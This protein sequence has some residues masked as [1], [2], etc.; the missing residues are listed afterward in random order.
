MTRTTPE[1]EPSSPD[2]RTTPVGGH[3]NFSD[4]KEGEGNECS[5]VRQDKLP[6]EEIVPILNHPAPMTW[7]L[8]AADPATRDF[9]GQYV[10]PGG[11]CF[12]KENCEE[13]ERDCT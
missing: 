10:S 3:M 9:Y 4:A 12:R 11:L 5:T 13:K 1:L 6:M 2:F 8:K 7:K